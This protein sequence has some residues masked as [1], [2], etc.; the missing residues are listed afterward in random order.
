M[1]AQRIVTPIVLA[2]V[3][4]RTGILTSSAASV[5]AEHVKTLTG[6]NGFGRAVCVDGDRIVIGAPYSNTAYS[7]QRNAGGL[8]NWGTT[9]NRSHTSGSYGCAVSASGDYTVVGA[10]SEDQTYPS[11][12]TDTGRAY[13]YGNF[14]SISYPYDTLDPIYYS[15]SYDNFG[16]SVSVDGD[17][18]AVGQPGATQGSAPVHKGAVR[19]FERWY[20]TLPENRSKTIWNPESNVF[21]AS[22]DRFGSS[23]ALS[24]DR[25]V[26]VA[27]SGIRTMVRNRGGTDNWGQQG[28]VMSGYRSSIALEGDR[29]VTINSSSRKAVVHTWDGTN[30]EAWNRWLSDPAGP[31]TLDTPP[32]SAVAISG[33]TIV[34]G[35]YVFQ[36]SSENAGEWHQIAELVPPAGVSNSFADTV[37]ISGDTIIAGAPDSNAVCI[38]RLR[39]I[40]DLRI[41]DCTMDEDSFSIQ[42]MGLEDW[43]FT[44]KYTDSLNPSSPWSNLTDHVDLTGFDGTMSATDTVSAIVRFYQVVGEPVADGSGSG[45][46][47]TE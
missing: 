39:E 42:W 35:P 32:V 30:G 17:L 38:Y 14:P 36:E 1:H 11:T 37:S 5:V 43:S 22:N 19:I 33:D 41:T 40:P 34:A 16:V 21:V 44:V 18:I 4:F 10:Y 3:L 24:G 15:D 2:A 9:G 45:R 25:L 6:N 23:V 12:E 7:Y 29:L 20:S 26:V 47:G 8:E 28:I 31:K 27:A 13:A 46:G